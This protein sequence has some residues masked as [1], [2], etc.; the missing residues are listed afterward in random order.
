MKTSDRLVEWLREHGYEI[1]GKP[2]RLYPGYWQRS[3]GAWVWVAYLKDRRGEVGSIYPMGDVVKWTEPGF[4][5]NHADSR[6]ID[7]YPS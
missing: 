3:A 7:V 4:L 1:E 5:P 2:E 6:I